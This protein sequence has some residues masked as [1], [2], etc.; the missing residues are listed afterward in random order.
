MVGIVI[1]S[2]SSKVADGI[3]D[4]AQQMAKDVNI[5]AAGGTADGEIG[6]D[7]FKIQEAILKANTGNGVLIMVDLGSAVLSAETALEF[8]DEELRQNVCIADAPIVEGTIVGAV[9]AS[10]G[11]M[12]KDVLKTA[13]GACT[14][15]KI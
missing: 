10:T 8:L 14:L 13:I 2:H 7:A 11:A 5:I 15:R 4:I 9:Q 6:T 3:K 1:V 12:L